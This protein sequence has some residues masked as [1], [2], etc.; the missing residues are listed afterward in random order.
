MSPVA[1]SASAAVNSGNVA[2]G[3]E[4]VVPSSDQFGNQVVGVLSNATVILL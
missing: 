1:A 4:M 2:I 3:T